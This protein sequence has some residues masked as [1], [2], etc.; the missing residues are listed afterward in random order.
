MEVTLNMNV[1]QFPHDKQ[2][3]SQ[4]DVQMT[5]SKDKFLQLSKDMSEA[6]EI[7]ENLKGFE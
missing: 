4:S 6:L 7:M 1:N 2:N 3:Q 5:M